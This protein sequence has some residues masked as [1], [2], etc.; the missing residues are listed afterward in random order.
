M[1]YKP[2]PGQAAGGRLGALVVGLITW[3]AS[4]PS[5]TAAEVQAENE[6]ARRQGI[7]HLRARTKAAQQHAR[8]G[9]TL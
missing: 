6:A 9:G 3:L 4:R 2:T 8:K 1:S 7:N 5:R